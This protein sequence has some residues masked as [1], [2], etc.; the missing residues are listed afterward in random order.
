MNRGGQIYR[1]VITNTGYVLRADPAASLGKQKQAPIRTCLPESLSDSH[2]DLSA[3]C[4]ACLY[5]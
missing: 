1:L 4:S 3:C 2:N 5:T